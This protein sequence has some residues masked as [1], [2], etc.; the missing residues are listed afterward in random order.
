[1]PSGPESLFEIVVAGVG[2]LR[3]RDVRRKKAREKVLM[4]VESGIFISVLKD[5]FQRCS[6]V[7]R[8]IE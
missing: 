2:E 7:P 8:L 5:F 3:E 6:R 1:M 4:L